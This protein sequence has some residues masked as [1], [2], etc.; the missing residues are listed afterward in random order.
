MRIVDRFTE[1]IDWYPKHMSKEERHLVFKIDWLVLSF[2]C[3]SYFTK[4]LDVSA[5][6]NAYISGMKEDLNL[7]GN[8]LNYATSM[9]TAPWL[10]AHLHP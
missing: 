7:G 8:R 4:N 10:M 6:T 9:C 5:L 1:I 2:T 3:I